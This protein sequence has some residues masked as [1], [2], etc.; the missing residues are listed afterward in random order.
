MVT[1][2]LWAGDIAGHSRC[3]WT[4]ESPAMPRIGEVVCVAADKNPVTKEPVAKDTLFQYEVT[5]V[6]HVTNDPEATADVE[7]YVTEFDAS[8]RMKGL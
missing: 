7:V 3:V 8:D 2:D 1:I 5:N 4:Y 6:F